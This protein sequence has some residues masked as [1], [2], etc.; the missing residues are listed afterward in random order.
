M[1]ATIAIAIPMSGARRIRCHHR[2]PELRRLPR[3]PLLRRR[4]RPRQLL[5]RLDTLTSTSSQ[6]A[7]ENRGDIRATV[8]QMKFVGIQLEH[9]LDQVSRRPLR[10]LTGVQ[11][12]NM[13][14]LRAASGDTSP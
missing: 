8:A 1:D 11:P 14:S 10:M 13:D 4:P 12:V 6:M 3:L 7:T 9:F 2:R 5:L